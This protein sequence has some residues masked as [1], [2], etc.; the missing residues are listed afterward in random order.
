MYEGFA[1]IILRMIN[2]G[3]T[4]PLPV[5]L[6]ALDFISVIVTVTGRSCIFCTILQNLERE[7]EIYRVTK[8]EPARNIYM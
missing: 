3:F 2:H 4:I 1:S 6:V 7:G 5:F 8:N